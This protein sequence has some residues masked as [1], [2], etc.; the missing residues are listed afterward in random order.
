MPILKEFLW[1]SHCHALIPK[2]YAHKNTANKFQGWV[3]AVFLR[4]F[5]PCL[6]FPTYFTI[7][8]ETR[9]AVQAKAMNPAFSKIAPVSGGPVDL[10]MRANSLKP[11]WQ[12]AGVGISHSQ[13]ARV[14]FVDK[15][16]SHLICAAS[17][18]QT[19]FSVGWG[20]L[21]V[22][23]QL[24]LEIR[25]PPALAGPFRSDLVERVLWF[26]WGLFPDCQLETRHY[27]RG[28]N[29]LDWRTSLSCIYIYIQILYYNYCTIIYMC[30]FVFVPL[31]HIPDHEAR[32]FTVQHRKY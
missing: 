13:R 29:G 26:L 14:N 17:R 16:I 18:R 23:Q 20:R 9:H 19:H 15:N 8:N 25:F 30:V 6:N 32:D 12:R 4:V 7:K 27:F 3:Q 5:T 1:I 31:H 21:S 2:G 22:Q 28:F 24:D 10:V 11:L